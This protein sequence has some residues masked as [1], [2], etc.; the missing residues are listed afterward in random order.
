[1]PNELQRMHHSFPKYVSL[2]KI[3]HIITCYY[4]KRTFV[5]NLKER[6]ILIGK[7]SVRNPYFNLA[8]KLTVSYNYRKGTIK[9]GK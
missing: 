3:M 6:K 4:L 2:S 8:W 7:K 5:F 1:M 9:L